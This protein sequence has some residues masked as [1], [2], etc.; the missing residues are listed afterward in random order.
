M[1]K[2]LFILALIIIFVLA[3]DFVEA[4]AQTDIDAKI[5]HIASYLDKPEGPGSDGKIMVTLLLEAILQAAPDT[6]FP[7][8]FAENMEKAKE[9]SDS[10]SVLNPDGIV[11]LHKAYQLINAGNDFQMPSSIREIQDA[12][13]QIKMD[14]ATARKKLKSGQTDACVKGL[15]EVAL[16]IVTPVQR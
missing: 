7:P 6:G 9:I 2:P 10:T 4:T 14:L 8:E 13:N 1:K 16:M 11:Y 12:V 5:K 3:I 15:L